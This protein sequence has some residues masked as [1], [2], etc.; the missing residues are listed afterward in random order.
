M[1][2]T[3]EE[4]FEELKRNTTKLSEDIQDE[5]EKILDKIVNMS[6]KL[7]DLKNES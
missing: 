6:D 2:A 1:T 5:I 4:Q 7:K 3:P